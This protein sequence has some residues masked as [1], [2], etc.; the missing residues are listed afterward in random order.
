MRGRNM[1]TA[2]MLT[3]LPN[4]DRKDNLTIDIRSEPA[5]VSFNGRTLPLKTGKPDLSSRLTIRTFDIA[6]SSLLLIATFPLFILLFISVKITSK[7]PA[8]YKDKR[9]SHRKP[10]FNLYKFRTMHENAEEILEELMSDE[11][12][13]TEYKKYAKLKQD[14]RITS[15]GSFLR[16]TS[17]DE[18][19]QLL[20]VLKGDMSLIGPRPKSQEELAVFSYAMP[21]ILRVKPGI[22]GL[23]QVSGRNELT[24]EERVML[25]VEYATTRSASQDI[26]I[27]FKTAKQ[28]VQPMS[29]GSY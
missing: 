21:T 1:T 22:T 20:N 5:T 7:G 27:C 12:M 4:L 16:K 15:I 6:S 10:Y 24:L 14:P 29:N 17:L 25:D 8:I 28:M 9:V 23:W 18:L 26:V 13:S 11:K 2:N 3:T 19:P